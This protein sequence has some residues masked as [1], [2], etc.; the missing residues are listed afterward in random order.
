MARGVQR[1]RVDGNHVEIVKA[2]RAA[3]IGAVSTA[4]LGN[5]FPDIAA[6]FRGLSFLFEVKSGERD[7]DRKLTADEARFHETWPG[8]VAVVSTAEEAITIVVS[9]AK[10]LGVM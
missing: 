4:A 7:C 9:E 8:Q 1:A 3:S 5:G 2:L 6:G 10:R